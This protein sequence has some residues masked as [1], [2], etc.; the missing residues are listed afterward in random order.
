MIDR[1]ISS[2]AAIK[3]C[4]KRKP[5]KKTTKNKHKKTYKK[6]QTK[7]LQANYKSQLFIKPVSCTRFAFYFSF[8]GIHYAK[9][10]VGLVA[11][12]LP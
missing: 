7:L 3:G 1:F 8:Y 11:G 5:K 6:E 10:S 4:W 12:T 2:E 9:S